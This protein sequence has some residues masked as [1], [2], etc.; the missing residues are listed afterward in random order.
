MSVSKKERWTEEDIVELPSGEHEYFDRKSG[1]LVGEADFFAKLA[2][3]LSAFAN[4]G[5]GHLFIGVQNDG[6]LDGVEPCKGRTRTRE[7]LEQ[8]CPNL[9][10]Y[11]LEDFRV[12]EVEPSTPSSIPEGK[13]VIVIDVADSPRAPHQSQQ[14]KKYYVRLGGR[15]EPASHRMIED[16]RNRTRH[17][18]LEVA[19]MEIQDFN[20]D[21]T[22]QDLDRLKLTI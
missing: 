13:V 5:G 20:W 6:T 18:D 9:V 17:P 22:G 3:A 1:K 16:I 14:D 19:V 4:S 12:H 10:E 2:K 7:W 21:P 15:S 11:A 8:V